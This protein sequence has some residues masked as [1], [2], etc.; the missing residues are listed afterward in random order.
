M[1]RQRY[2]STP[3]CWIN[4]AGQDYNSSNIITDTSGEDNFG[5]Q[6]NQ[7]NYQS[8]DLVWTE[9]YPSID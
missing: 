3:T 5:Y 4:L 8:I 1:A 6:R 7:S 9:G 2:G